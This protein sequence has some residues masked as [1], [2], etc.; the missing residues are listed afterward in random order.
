MKTDPSEGDPASELARLQGS[1]ADWLLIQA[2][3]LTGVAAA[4][5]VLEPRDRQMFFDAIDD[6]GRSLPAD[7]LASPRRAGALFQGMIDSLHDQVEQFRDRG[8]D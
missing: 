1:I 2:A 3:F 4:L 8:G 6:A 7:D 5:S